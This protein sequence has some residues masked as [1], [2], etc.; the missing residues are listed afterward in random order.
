MYSN[1]TPYPLTNSKY[2]LDLIHSG[3]RRLIVHRTIRGM[4]QSIQSLRLKMYESNI[5]CN[6][7]KPCYWR[8]RL[9]MQLHRIK[10]I[11]KPCFHVFSCWAPAHAMLHSVTYHSSPLVNYF[12]F[13]QSR[14]LSHVFFLVRKAMVSTIETAVSIVK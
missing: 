10:S 4:S 13:L 1:V 9:G 2:F 14:F 3:L 5:G 7:E 8:L 6:F 12:P 11:V